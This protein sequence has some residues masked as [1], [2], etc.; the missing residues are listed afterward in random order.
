MK[1]TTIRALALVDV[2]R[3]EIHELARPEPNAGEVLVETEAVGLCG[4]DFHIHSGHANYNLDDS[5]RP[6]P[7][8]ES[9]QILGHEIV[10]RVVELGAGVSDLAEGDSVLVDQGLQCMSAGLDSLCEYCASGD[11]HQCEGYREYGITGVPGGFAGVL[12]VPAV[13]CVK[14]DTAIPADVAVLSEPLGCV[15]HSMERANSMPTRYRFEQTG[16]GQ[17]VQTAVVLGA[18]PAGLLFLQHIRRVSGFDG[19]VLVS[20]PNPAKRELANDLGGE[21]VAPEQLEAAVLERSNGRRAEFLVEASGS[22]SVYAQIPSLIRKHA[23]VVAYGIGHR[24]AG[25]TLLSQVQWKE[26]FMSLSV[27]ASGG[28]DPDGR[29]SIYRR[30][31]HL[32]QD[33]TIQG[34]A[35]I[36]HRFHG[37]DGL[38]RAFEGGNKDAGYIKGAWVVSE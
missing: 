7:L 38:Q 20:D 37:L 24:D 31:L 29:P 4:T 3:F 6:I 11:S 5:G 2:R 26:A 13:N 1:P 12:G 35:I 16:G 21:A 32:L 33:E 15:L 28:F 14:R 8:A 9:P 30:A 36:S 17:A 19:P 25:L 23:T 27:G 22:G 18:G 34:D 10:G